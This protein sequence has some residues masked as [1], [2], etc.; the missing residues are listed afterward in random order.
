MINILWYYIL[1]ITFSF[2]FFLFFFGQQI[3]LSVVL[4]HLFLDKTCIRYFQHL[5]PDKNYNGRFRL[6]S[7]WTF[8]KFLVYNGTSTFFSTFLRWLIS[9]RWD[10]LIE[11]SKATTL[12]KKNPPRKRH[13]YLKNI[14]SSLFFLKLESMWVQSEFCYKSLEDPQSISIEGIFS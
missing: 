12:L 6:G 4:H 10:Q 5:G 7:V 11:T 3:S 1:I 13:M 9:Q 14:D 2:S 8:L